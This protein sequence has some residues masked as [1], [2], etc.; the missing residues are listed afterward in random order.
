[1]TLDTMRNNAVPPE[2]MALRYIK[3]AITLLKDANN[4]IEK[5]GEYLKITKAFRFDPDGFPDTNEITD[6]TQ[7]SITRSQ[8]QMDMLHCIGYFADSKD[9]EHGKAD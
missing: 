1:M 6:L 8:K 9:D 7:E 2:E 4:A 3:E 5:Y